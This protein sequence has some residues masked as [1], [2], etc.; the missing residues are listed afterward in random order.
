MFKV[1]SLAN[2]CCCCFFVIGKPPNARSEFH[3]YCQRENVKPRFEFTE[4][5]TERGWLFKCVVS[6]MLSGKTIRENSQG[7][8]PRKD[9]AKEIACGNILR[10]IEN[11][12]VQS[13]GAVDGT[14][15]WISKLKEHY[16]KKGE[17]NQPLD[18][19]VKSVDGSSPHF[20][21]YIYIKELNRYVDGP[22]AKSK[23]EAKQSA[24]KSAL[25]L[26]GQYTL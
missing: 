10:T 15:S 24:A 19:Q 20:V 3:N 11:H 6:V 12:P 14:V 5:E 7:Y 17:P 1:T 18:I 25:Q 16:D 8:Y 26:L 9:D 21:A 2:V 4:E 13:R 23:K 22:S